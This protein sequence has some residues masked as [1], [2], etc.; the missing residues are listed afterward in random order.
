MVACAVAF[1]PS[2]LIGSVVAAIAA[3]RGD[4]YGLTS[5]D[6]TEIGW[7]LTICLLS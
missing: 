2:S 6:V 3:F 5:S 7:T 1:V 4:V